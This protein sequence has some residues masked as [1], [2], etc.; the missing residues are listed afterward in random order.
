M[1]TLDVRCSIL[2]SIEILYYSI[3]NN[4]KLL[5]VFTAL[6]TQFEEGIRNI[7]SSGE[8]PVQNPYFKTTLYVFLIKYVPNFEFDY[9]LNILIIIL[10]I[11]LIIRKVFG[12]VIR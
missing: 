8:K 1:V 11:F 2:Y 5:C 12:L 3:L 10:M 9:F 6:L 7:L 4:I